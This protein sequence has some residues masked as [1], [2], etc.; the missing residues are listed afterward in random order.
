MVNYDAD[1]LHN[2]SPKVVWHTP[3]IKRTWLIALSSYSKDLWTE[4]LGTDT[5]LN[6]NNLLFTS[7][8]IYRKASMIAT[9]SLQKIV[10]YEVSLKQHYRH[11]SIHRTNL[12]Q[13][14]RGIFCLWMESTYLEWPSY[15]YAEMPKFIW[16]AARVASYN[17]G[18]WPMCC[19][20]GYVF[21][22]LRVFVLV[23]NGFQYFAQSVMILAHYLIK[24]NF[25]YFN[26]LN[27]ALCYF[28]Y[29]CSL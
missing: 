20:F 25:F 27:E 19:Y 28:F 15:M 21:S 17:S 8:L 24:I 22:E 4:N 29:L 10:Y 14:C 13:S 12:S 1:H 9:R 2:K 6:F 18:E 26:I 11:N 23:S 16:W 3:A 5:L 7:W